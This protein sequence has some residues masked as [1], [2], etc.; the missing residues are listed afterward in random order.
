MGYDKAMFSLWLP[1]KLK[2]KLEAIAKSEGRSLASLI[3]FYL[4]NAV[5]DIS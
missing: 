4:T 3:V 2:Q 1:V 5:K